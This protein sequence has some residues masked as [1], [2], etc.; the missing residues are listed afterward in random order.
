LSFLAILKLTAVEAKG[1]FDCGLQ[2]SD[3]GFYSSQ[4]AIRNL[5]SEM[6]A[7]PVRRI[8][9]VKRFVWRKTRILAKEALR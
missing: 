2:I 8:L 1:R 4:S 3:C 9:S 7:K 6:T 5:Q